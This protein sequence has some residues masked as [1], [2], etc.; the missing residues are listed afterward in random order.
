M[1]AKELGIQFVHIDPHYNS[2]AQF[3]GGKWLPVRPTTDSAL[4]HAIMHVWITEGL[5]DA[6]FV[7]RCTTGFEEWRAYILG[8][9]DGVPKTPVWQEAETGIPAKD[10][11][12]LAR[13]WGSKKTYLAAGGIGTGFGG[14]CRSA[15]GQQWARNMILLMAM[16][17]WGRPG[18]NFGNLQCGVP[19]DLAPYFPGYAEGGISGDL[20]KTASSINNYVRMPHVLTMNPAMQRIPRER[21][22]EGVTQGEADAYMWDGASI[23]AQFRKV[24]YPEPGHAKIHM[25]YQYGGSSFG[26]TMDSSRLIDMYRDES[27]DLVVSQA[28]WQEGETQFA[29]IILPAC[30]VLERYDISEACGCAG[31]A[32]HNQSQINHRIVTMQHKCIEPIG[33][34]KSD[35]R[36]FADILTR[37]GFGS[38]FTEGC[39]EL[40]WCKRVF[41]SSDLPNYISW[42][43][44]LKKGYVV[45]PPQTPEMRDPVYMR[46]FYEGR[47]K[48]VA[49]PHPLPAD[50]SDFLEGLQTQSGKIEFLPSS[51]E[52]GDPNNAERPVLNRYIPAWEGRHSAHLMQEYPLQIVSSHPRYSFHT[53]ADGKNSPIV[54]I[55]DHR[56]TVEGYAYWVIRMNSA[57][58]E[59]RGLTQHCLVKVF[60]ERAAVICA[61]DISPLVARGAIKTFESSAEFDFIEDADGKVVDRG[62]CINL[63]TPSRTQA[64]GTSAI[65]PN[66][67][68][69]QVERWNRRW[70]DAG[71]QVESGNRH[72][73][74]HELQ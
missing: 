16:Q 54:D 71:G 6:E 30:S 20:T 34:S 38:M 45:I 4:A 35:Y 22:S 32:H 1:W 7:G 50:Y 40:D 69:V 51:L 33:E 64:T 5:Y 25:I 15:T 39:D 41:E 26:T 2:T 73:R 23:E 13:L 66:S 59:A 44:F 48:D 9:N 67:C 29:D 58:A 72:I 62:G 42:S 17:G 74:V 53:Q 27:V 46:W 70:E 52:R 28:I 47:K 19:L 14:A 43:E 55:E 10:V 68:L 61:V 18:V 60:N 11:I 56:V 12:S 65:A 36:I 24:H 49:E 8:E 31:F 57:D 21:S 3:L 37:L 63:L